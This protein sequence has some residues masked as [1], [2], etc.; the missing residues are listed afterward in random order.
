MRTELQQIW[1][2]TLVSAS[3]TP[4]TI[5]LCEAC[6]STAGQRLPLARRIDTIHGLWIRKMWE[7]GYY[8]VANA[9][10][11]SSKCPITASAPNSPG[12]ASQNPKLT[13]TDGIPAACAARVS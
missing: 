7:V 5:R 12:A 9:A 3:D 4:C 2:C 6:S 1:T 8:S 10:T 11:N 13:A